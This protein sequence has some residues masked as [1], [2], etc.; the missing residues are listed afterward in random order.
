MLTFHSKLCFV[1]ASRTFYRFFCGKWNDKLLIL[2]AR[3][4]F[5]FAI[6]SVIKTDY[7]AW[8]L[9]CDAAEFRLLN[10]LIYLILTVQVHNARHRVNILFTLLQYQLLKCFCF[11]QWFEMACVPW[12]SGFLSV[13]LHFKDKYASDTT[14]GPCFFVVQTRSTTCA[15]TTN[16]SPAASDCICYI[17]HK[18]EQNTV[19]LFVLVTWSMKPH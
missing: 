6:I 2:I 9:M 19:T 14:T 13:C 5:F 16:Q 7:T 12:L 10:I 15:M 11:R 17:P 4:T 18:T 8:S 1:T 3:N